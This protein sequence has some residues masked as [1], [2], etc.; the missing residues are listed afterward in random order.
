MFTCTNASSRFF[1]FVQHGGQNSA[2]GRVVSIQFSV[3]LVRDSRVNWKNYILTCKWQLCV[4][5]KII[6]FV[7]CSLRNSGKKAWKVRLWHDW[8]TCFSDT[9]PLI[10]LTF[11]SHEWPR[12]NFSYNIRTISVQYQDNIITISAQY[13][14]NISTISVQYHADKWWE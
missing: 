11:N 10:L 13:Q 6:S 12:Q 2:T 4:G 5:K 1:N 9:T 14:H 3:V 7:N 8:N